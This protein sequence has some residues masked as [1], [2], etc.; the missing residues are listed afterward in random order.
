MV[1]SKSIRP[2]ILIALLFL[3][4]TGFSQERPA[5]SKSSADEAPL[6]A[7]VDRFFAAYAKKDLDS[8]MQLW[9]AKS[10]EVDSRRK[11][12][13][14]VFG[15]NGKIEL[16]N[17]SVRNVAIDG[18]KARV[19]VIAEISA[20]DAKTGKAAVGFGK[21]NRAFQLVKED[22]VWKVWSESSA[23]D[24][25]VAAALAAKSEAER[26]SL[27]AAEKELVTVELR[28]ALIVQGRRLDQRGDY[29]QALIL[30]QLAQT[31][32][33][34]I[35]DQAGIVSSL[36]RIGTVY[37]MQGNF[38]SSMDYLQKVLP[39]AR[40]SQDKSAMAE[41][42]YN[43]GIIHGSRGE[44]DLAVETLQNGLTLSR[45]A[46]N[47]N[48]SSLAL[49]GVAI[50]YARQGQYNQALDSFQKS[51][52]IQNELGNK[53]VIGAILQNVGNIYRHQGNY[54]LALETYQKGLRLADEVGNKDTVAQLLNNIGNI[55]YF[56]SD[57]NL[58]LEFYHKSLA[59]K[60]ELGQKVGIA[61]ALDNIG[62]IYRELGNYGKAL[63]YYKKS[64]TIN[65][66]IKATANM[67]TLLADI[68]NTYRLYGDYA[69][70]LDYTRRS[71]KL[72]ESLGD[73]VGAIASLSQIA[74]V[75]LA[76]KDYARSLESAERATSIARQI[77][78]RNELWGALVTTGK[79]Q[80]A[81]G[82][83]VQAR[84]SFDDAIETI[85]SLRS[86]VAGGE[87]QQQ[88]FFADKLAPYH[89]AVGLLLAQNKTGEALAYAER[90]RARVLLDVL[91]SGRVNVT[92]ALTAQEQ[93]RE[94]SLNTQ[95]VSLNA[96]IGREE[97]RNQPDPAHISDLKTRLRTA[98]LDYEAFQNS[99][100]AA[101]SELKVQRGEA[102]TIK[103]E[104]MAELLPD[105]KSALLEYVVTDEMT[106]LFVLT[107]G[108]GD[109]PTTVD[110]KVYPITIKQKEL[111][112]RAERFRRSL[113]VR[114]LRFRKPATELYDLL[115]KPARAELRAKTT[116]VI[117]PDG[118]LW[119]LPF[120][121]LQPAPNRYVLED[122]A[123]S[124]SPSLT[125][126]REMSRP[127]K[128]KSQ[129]IASLLAVGNPSP[130][131]R[132]AERSKAVNRDEDSAPLPEA[133]K[134]VEALRR[135]YGAARTRVYVGAEAREDRIKTEAG[136]YGILHLATHGVLNNAS[137]MYSHLVLSQTDGSASEDGLLETWEIMNL[138]LKA[139]LV[140]LS[141]CETARGRVT[142]GEG[143]IGLAWALFVAGCPTAVVSQWKVDSAS[144]TA[145]MLEFHKQLRNATR[146]EG[147]MNVAKS[148]REAALRLLRKTEYRHPFYWAG[149][150]VVGAGS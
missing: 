130:G 95:M 43:I 51:L 30:Y 105:A 9:S 11:A 20:V 98:R 26:A 36:I 108:S 140:V 37:R 85:E 122:H 83:T 45:E 82:Q 38:N 84:Q 78:E 16:I 106:Y 68:G 87:Q 103:L 14:E 48:L 131:K 142:A 120:Q 135:L 33:E 49:N 71:L 21:M 69:Q 109:S 99:L 132:T 124:Y 139:R 24:D 72:S 129:T 73:Q 19:R 10:P 133:E 119:Q 101:H 70:A 56:Q 63:E 76:Q 44:F 148:L 29:A 136:Q 60:E 23:E 42:F 79:A 28:K 65:E 35:G 67:P 89:E 138:D 125:V 12:M 31:V 96:L 102:Q 81:L 64:Q 8:F 75:H 41:V 97:S 7:L 134:E 22:G 53:I 143:V 145:L 13:G 77:G 4:G 18:E 144:T 86:D 39:L 61:T 141:A 47:K 54:G 115:L 126:L 100:Y 121:A 91:R 92:K 80:G 17:L 113:A 128:R 88:S 5:G 110:V 57:Y 1:S 15:A 34:K 93:S 114:D 32:A 116:L 90:A 117:V 50:T 27:L 112:E 52:R 25:L 149:F 111:A 62:N 59:L 107:H 40:D 123:I 55:Y 66:E 104:E 118:V 46:G 147:Q 3:S 6:R 2:R 127:R 58:A 74:R 146:G 150:I 94:R 137:P